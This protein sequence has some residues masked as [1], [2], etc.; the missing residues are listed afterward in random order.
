MSPEVAISGVLRECEWDIVL[1]VML[2]ALS[3]LLTLL[4][5]LAVLG[6]VRRSRV[7]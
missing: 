4:W 1:I 7:C 2:C 6:Y 5:L 3:V